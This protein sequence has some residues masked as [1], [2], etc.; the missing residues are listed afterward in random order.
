MIFHPLFLS[1]P[2]IYLLLIKASL[3]LYFLWEEG[4]WGWG[5][6]PPVDV[7]SIRIS[8]RIS[9]LHFSWCLLKLYQSQPPHWHPHPQWQNSEPLL[10]TFLIK[11]YFWLPFLVF[12]LSCLIKNDDDDSNSRDK[13][14]PKEINSSTSQ[15]LYHFSSFT[16]CLES[17]WRR[18]LLFTNLWFP[19]ILNIKAIKAGQGDIYY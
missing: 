9:F 17:A 5:K 11:K 12:I 19:E 16:S 13:M 7:I 18:G 3:F 1:A 10:Q 4:G 15:D 14:A 2:L 8:Y 6:I